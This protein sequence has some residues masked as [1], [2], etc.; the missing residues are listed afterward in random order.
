MSNETIIVQPVVYNLTVTEPNAL[1]QVSA[2]G[3]QGATGSSGVVSVNLP[4]LNT[5]TS[6]SAV[7]SL[8]YSDLVVNGGA[9]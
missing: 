8:S 2:P 5:G 3:P 6:T 1:V 9:A 4:L 7:L